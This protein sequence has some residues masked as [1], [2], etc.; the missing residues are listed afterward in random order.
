MGQKTKSAVEQ[1]Q[2]DN[3]LVIDGIIGKQVKDALGIS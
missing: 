3:G 2:K 1:F